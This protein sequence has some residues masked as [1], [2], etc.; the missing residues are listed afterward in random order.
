ME[1]GFNYTFAID[2]YLMDHSGAVVLN[3]KPA[4]AARLAMFSHRFNHTFHQSCF[5]AGMLRVWQ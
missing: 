3:G 4:A 5:I 1:L 2:D